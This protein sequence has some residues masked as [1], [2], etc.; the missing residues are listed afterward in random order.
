MEVQLLK[1]L[2]TSLF[3]PPLARGVSRSPLHWHASVWA[4][5]AVAHAVRRAL[6]REINVMGP[7]WQLG[8][9]FPL[10][11]DFPAQAFWFFGRQ[12]WNIRNRVIDGPTYHHTRERRKEDN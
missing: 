7:L 6:I 1:Q 2:A 11:V 8:A 3:Q 5:P 9:R 12:L 4:K 10:S